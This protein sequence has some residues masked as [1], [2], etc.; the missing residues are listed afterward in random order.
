MKG[1]KVLRKHALNHCPISFGPF[2]KKK[3]L[4]LLFLVPHVS[5]LESPGFELKPLDAYPWN[6]SDYSDTSRAPVET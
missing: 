5:I 1:A 3:I 4:A 6:N 2:V